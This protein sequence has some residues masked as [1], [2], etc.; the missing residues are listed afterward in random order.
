M[1]G[2]VRTVCF[3]SD[4]TGVTAETLGHS[5][6]S[7]FGGVTF[8]TVTMPFVLDTVQARGVV[9]RINALGEERGVKPIVFCTVV[10]QDTRAVIKQASALVIDLLSTLLGQL[11]SGRLNP[12]DRR[13]LEEWAELWYRSVS[14]VFLKRY[15]EAAAG[16]P[17]VPKDR[18]ELRLLLDVFMVE[19]AL[20]EIAYELHNRP[21]W[22]GIPLRGIRSI[23]DALGP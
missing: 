3:V 9:A 15:L 6:L 1:T 4:R 14:R 18:E 8:H 21:T 19:K 7:L 10:D 20:Y 13:R 22:L 23:L 12:G 5:L 11:E 2:T 16:A 17:F